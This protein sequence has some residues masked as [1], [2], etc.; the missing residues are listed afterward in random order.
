MNKLLILFVLLTFGSIAQVKLSENFEVEAGKPYQVIDAPFKYYFNDSEN[1]I[2]SV[3]IRGVYLTIQKFSST[4][5]EELDR[6]MYKDMPKGVVIQKLMEVEG[7]LVILFEQY[8]RKTKTSTLYSKKINYDN[9]SAEKP[10]K[11]LTTKRPVIKGWLNEEGNQPVIPGA[12][13]NWTFGVK[14]NIH[15]SFDKSKILIQY[16]LKPNSRRDKINK[17]ELGFW[18]FDNEFQLLWSK[19]ELMPYT[20][21]EMNNLAY[22][23]SSK[24]EIFML[25]Q[26]NETKSFELLKVTED[27][28]ITTSKLD[29]ENGIVFEKMKLIESTNGDI[30]CA[31]YYANGI[32]IKFN[33]TFDGF[34]SSTSFNCDGIYSF[35]VTEDGDVSDVWKIPFSMEL[36]ELYLN[37]RQQKKLNEREEKGNAG[38]PDLK[39][40]EFYTQK[41]GSYIIVGEQQYMRS[42]LYGPSTSNIYHY[43]SVIIC[44]ISPDGD[45]LWIEK[46]GKNQFAPKGDL[47]NG[48]YK[49]QMSIKYI[50]GNSKHYILYVDNPKNAAL[51]TNQVPERHKSG[52][53]GFITAVEILDADGEFSRHTI[54]E[55]V[56]LD[57]VRAYQFNITRICEVNDNEFMME[58]YKK[59]KEDAM[60]KLTL[61]KD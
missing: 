7:G 36:K 59:K 57:G 31:G 54:A 11:I 9:L 45:L 14:F 4:E 6:K 53:G 44:K 1:N 3:K 29:I 56:D 46:I 20:E 47:Y 58:V 41:D 39:M 50:R 49:G 5:M 22:T 30:T 15:Q 34:S 40:L 17:D 61:L 28:A 37:E 23:I 8:D 16:R 35:K 21:A 38:I 32:D 12:N 10:K 43:M 19:E 33:A 24:G 26:L 18:V 25:A 52:S 48:F 51:Q 27:N 13:S 60:I 2:I 55:L 42:E